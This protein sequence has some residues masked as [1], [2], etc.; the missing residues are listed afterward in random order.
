MAVCGCVLD[1]GKC[2]LTEVKV[3]QACLDLSWIFGH[4]LTKLKDNFHCCLSSS[5]RLAIFSTFPQQVRA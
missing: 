5:L 4:I 2:D 3:L 1:A